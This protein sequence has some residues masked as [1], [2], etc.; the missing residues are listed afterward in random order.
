MSKKRAGLIRENRNLTE[1]KYSATALQENI[2]TRIS[3]ELQAE[4]L[5]KGEQSFTIE[6]FIKIDCSDLTT[7]DSYDKVV[8]AAEALSNVKF[9]FKTDKSSGFSN[10]ISGAKH[11]KGDNFITVIIPSLT[12]QALCDLNM[13]YALLLPLVYNLKSRYSKR[14]YKYIATW[15]DRGGVTVSIKHLREMLG[16]EK[17]KLSANA[18]FKRF[19]LEVASKEL[20]EKS[21][22][23][24]E[25]SFYRS[26]KQIK[27]K[28]R[29]HD[30]IKFKIFTKDNMTGL[31]KKVRALDDNR[32][33]EISNFLYTC[34][35]EVKDLDKSITHFRDNETMKYSFYEKIKAKK[36]AFRELSS[37]HRQNLVMKI[38]HDDY[39]L[40]LYPSFDF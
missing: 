37:A 25:Y 26:E 31:V 15:N 40:S 29:T 27:A 4:L 35:F 13:G 22:I 12:K 33:K 30:M 28:K 39:K 9:R 16:I 18:D 8:A 17:G 38:L 34:G 20:K 3:E 5:Q 36:T 19:V 32:L 24:F 14:L 10:I 21:N 2:I 6:S 1:G 7:D 23:W 11:E